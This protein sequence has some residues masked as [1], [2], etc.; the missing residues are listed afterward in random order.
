MTKDW[1]SNLNLNIVII[2]FKRIQNLHRGWKGLEAD[3]KGV[4]ASDYKIFI[5]ELCRKLLIYS[6]YGISDSEAGYNSAHRFVL[7]HTS[8]SGS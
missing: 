2:A 1:Q 3:I 4:L 8:P 7:I 6:Y 5:P